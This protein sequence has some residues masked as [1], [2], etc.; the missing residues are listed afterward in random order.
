MLYW[1]IYVDI[2]R[3]KTGNTPLQVADKQADKQTHK[4]QYRGSSDRQRNKPRGGNDCL[5][6]SK[7]LSLQE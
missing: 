6:I 2:K 7:L 3:E 1:L 5:T 4:Q